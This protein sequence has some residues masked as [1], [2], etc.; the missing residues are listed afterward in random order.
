MEFIS[1]AASPEAKIKFG[2][3]YDDNLG[4]KLRITVIAT[5][6]PAKR[7]RAF[8]PFGRIIS[9]QGRAGRGLGVSG[10]PGIERASDAPSHP[11]DWGK[12]AY[13]RWKVR[14]LR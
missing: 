12:P 8:R 2:Q 3:V 4:D 9:G 11:E 7:V 1:R 13:L 5:G 10:A 6:F 14:K